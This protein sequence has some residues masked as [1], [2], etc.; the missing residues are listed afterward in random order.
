MVDFRWCHVTDIIFVNRAAGRLGTKMA[1]VE[2]CVLC[3]CGAYTIDDVLSE[4]EEFPNGSNV[5]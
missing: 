5:V 2:R 3:L 4:S 1:A